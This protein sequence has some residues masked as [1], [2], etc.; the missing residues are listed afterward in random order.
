MDRVVIRG[1]DVLSVK[2]EELQ[3]DDI[4]F[5]HDMFWRV[6]KEHEIPRMRIMEL[7]EDIY[8]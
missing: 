8:H 1:T 2:E 6:Q 4:V 5:E 3:A 7:S